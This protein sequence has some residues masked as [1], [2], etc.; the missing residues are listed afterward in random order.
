MLEMHRALNNQFIGQPAGQHTSKSKKLIEDLAGT[1][2]T[3]ESQQKE[4]EWLTLREALVVFLLHYFRFM[5][6]KKEYYL[7]LIGSSP[8]ILK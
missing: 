1:I 3:I 7:K 2:T 6:A 4:T 5:M 8:N